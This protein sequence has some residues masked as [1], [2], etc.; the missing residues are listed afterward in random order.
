[1]SL[2][3]RI[4]PNSEAAP[5]VVNEVRDLE[6]LKDALEAENDKLKQSL[7][8]YMSELAEAKK[9]VDELGE[10]LYHITGSYE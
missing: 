9:R 3:N 10:R 5:W 6:K 7:S 8:F 2:S 1:M 4:R